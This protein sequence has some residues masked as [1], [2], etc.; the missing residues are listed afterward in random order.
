MNITLE[1]F[2]PVDQRIASLIRESDMPHSNLEE[3]R[4]KLDKI[5]ESLVVK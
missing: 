4:A 2:L 5:A 1:L 3:S